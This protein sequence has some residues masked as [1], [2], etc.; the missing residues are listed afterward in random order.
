VWRCCGYRRSASCGRRPGQA[1]SSHPSPLSLSLLRGSA[2]SWRVVVSGGACGNT[3]PD[4]LDS[5][6][7]VA[8]VNKA[9]YFYRLAT[10]FLGINFWSVR[11][12]QILWSRIWFF[13]S[14]TL[15]FL[16]NN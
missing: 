9:C 11:E 14:P 12:L 15:W 5:F 2:D 7:F 16:I 13:E 10:F 4:R 3:H 8:A 6:T 1:S